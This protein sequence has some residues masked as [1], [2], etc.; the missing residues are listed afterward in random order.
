MTRGLGGAWDAEAASSWTVIT[1]KVDDGRGRAPP[2]TPSCPQPARSDVTTC[3]PGAD[4]MRCSRRSST[5]EVLMLAGIPLD[6]DGALDSAGSLT[7]RLH[8]R[9]DTRR[10]LAQLLRTVQPAELLAVET[11]EVPEGQELDDA[12][13]GSCRQ[14]TLADLAGGVRHRTVTP[15]ASVT[16]PRLRELYW[17]PIV[18]AGDQVRTIEGLPPKLL[19][20]DRQIA[21]VE[22]PGGEF[23]ALVTRE[24]LLLQVMLQTF[25]I[26]WAA[27]RPFRSAEASGLL[28]REVLELLLQGATDAA[29][30]RAL[31]VSERTV[32]RV[33]AMHMARH[34]VRTRMQLGALGARLF[35]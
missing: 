35:D 1:C 29:V 8:R 30:A 22:S 6:G 33:V 25:E 7:H 18:E 21:V 28:E 32:R 23:D 11:I 16:D 13:L 34:D 2:F 5:P 14:R 17:R 19:I 24:P 20:I 27:G 12:Y 31:Y 3:A 4:A 26:L 15:A 9:E 10:Y